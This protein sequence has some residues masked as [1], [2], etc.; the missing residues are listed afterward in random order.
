[1]ALAT[2][3][4]DVIANTGRFEQDLNRKLKKAGQAAGKSFNTAFTKEVQSASRRLGID[5]D[6]SGEVA[7]SGSDAGRDWSRNFKR[8][9]GSSGDLFSGL[10]RSGGGGFGGMSRKLG[11]LAAAATAASAALGPLLGYLTAIPAVIAGTIG[12]VGT[13]AV[14]LSC[15]VDAYGYAII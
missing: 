9:L 5:I 11:V 15:V 3:E 10:S 13:L 1:M 2:A 12:H 7:K 8:A 4:V 6:A 14:D